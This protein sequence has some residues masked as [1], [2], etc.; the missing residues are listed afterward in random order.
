MGEYAQ[1]A[2]KSDDELFAAVGEALGADSK[3]LLPPSLDEKIAL[4][5][6]WLGEKRDWICEIVCS[7]AGVKEALREGMSGR[8]LTMIVVD[9]LA[10]HSLHMPVPPFALGMLFCRFSYHRTCT[11]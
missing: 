2:D 1:W 7:H 4:G 3:G 11:H 9:V 6:A 8:E 10:H 5:K